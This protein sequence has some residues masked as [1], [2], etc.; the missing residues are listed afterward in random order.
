MGTELILDVYA[1]ARLNDVYEEIHTNETYLSQEKKVEASSRRL[2]D[3][4]NEDSRIINAFIKYCENNERLHM[5]VENVYYKYGFTDCIALIFN[6]LK[7]L[8]LDMEFQN[9]NM[10]ED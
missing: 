6:S 10:H 4:I 1:N 5:A 9:I 2:N 3:E 7:G 8:D